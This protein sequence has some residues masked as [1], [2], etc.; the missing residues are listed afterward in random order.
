[1]IEAMVTASEGPVRFYKNM[2]HH[3]DGIGDR[4]FLASLDNFVL[5]RPPVDVIR[6]LSRNMAEP[7]LRDLGY[8]HLTEIVDEL[9][10]L[11]REPVVVVSSDVLRDPAG[12][13]ET[14]CGRLGIAWDPAMLSWDAGPRPE[15]G[16]WAKHW[17][18]N[19]HASTG[20]MRYRPNDE[21]LDPRFADLLAE[22]TP[23]YERLLEHRLRP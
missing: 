19:V 21:P 15:D 5:T 8:V 6:S 18:A 1:V 7:T 22:A 12:V 3:L 14:L 10:A 20:F 2:G 16:V 13:L 9:I 23:H 4:S 11:G 17:Y